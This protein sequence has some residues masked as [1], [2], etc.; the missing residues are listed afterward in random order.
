MSSAKE[1]RCSSYTVIY[2]ISYALMQSGISVHNS[3]MLM[4]MHMPGISIS[5]FVYWLCFDSQPV[6]N[7]CGPGLYSILML[8]WCIHSSI[9]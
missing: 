5:P 7:R 6:M 1:L 9:L 3:I 2:L 8:C 4:V